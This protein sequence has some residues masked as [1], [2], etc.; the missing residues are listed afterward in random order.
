M[1]YV[2]FIVL[3][4]FL[5]IAYN[6]SDQDV[7][8]PSFIFTSSFIFCVGWAIPFAKK[9]NLSLHTNTFLTFFLGVGL[10]I[11]FSWM[12]H[13]LFVH[14]KD[15]NRIEEAPIL[16]KISIE[17]WKLL[18]FILFEF[19]SIYYTVRILKHVTGM[20]SITDAILNY[21][22]ET[23]L[24]G[25]QYSFP[26]LMVLMRLITNAAG[27][28]FA[29]IF[30]NNYIVT[31]KFDV[32]S[33]III[34]L[35]GIS[36]SILGGRGNAINLLIG[37]VVIFY[38]LY[39]AHNHIQIGINF[40]ML[41][42]GLIAMFAILMIFQLFGTILGRSSQ[43][44]PL[45]YLAKYCGAEIKN[46]D[47]F[48]QNENFPNKM[49]GWGSQTFVNVIKSIGPY[50]GITNTE[51]ALDLPFLQVNGYNLGNVYTTFYPYIYDFGYVGVLFLVPLMAI[52]LQVVYENAKHIKVGR[53]Y[54]SLI[55]YSYMF[56]SILLSFFSNKFY[57]QN[58]STTFVLTVIVWGLF[59]L[60]FR[61]LQAK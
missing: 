54:L 44:D 51:Y 42:L 20:G 2:L 58:F 11:L 18:L 59:D 56:S 39:I 22:N 12:T 50:I 9:W 57:E 40:K 16:K 24:T 19:V 43:S 34:I 5:V 55:L 7:M 23:V 61:K 49:N 10:F 17:K 26:Q 35:S 21:R 41:I 60:F 30:S 37:F 3:L 28:W 31:H 15:D 8:A 38:F 6:A 36:N 14:M 1:L 33:L 13:F 48:L 46:L 27:Y 45:E 53:P 32:Y 29:F 4:A 52:I 47:V 25:V